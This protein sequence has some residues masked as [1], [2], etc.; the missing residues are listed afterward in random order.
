M[1]LP[2]PRHIFSNVTLIGCVS[3]ITLNFILSRFL[4]ES[5]AS[6]LVLNL[7]VVLCTSQI[8]YAILVS[9]ESPPSSNRDIWVCVMLVA[10]GVLPLIF[11]GVLVG[12]PLTWFLSN[13]TLAAFYICAKFI[14]VKL[15]WQLLG[16]LN[17]GSLL[18]V[19]L[20]PL[21][22]SEDT[23]SVIFASRLT[24]VLGHPNVT[25]YMAVCTIVLGLYLGKKFTIYMLCAALVTVATFSLTSFLALFA[26]LIVLVV[27]KKPRQRLFVSK[28]ALGASSF[29]LVGV[30]V[31]G[32]NLGPDLFTN[33]S[34]IWSWLRSYGTP[35]P[36]GYGLGFL[37]QQQAAG[38]V[39]WVHAHNQLMMNY[40]T[41]GIVGLLVVCGLLI[42]LMNGAEH[43]Q[44]SSALF[45]MLCVECTTEIPLFLDYPSGRWIGA[46]LVLVLIRSFR[47][48]KP[49][50]D[51]ITLTVARIKAKSPKKDQ[52]ET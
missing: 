37:N 52:L 26:G 38:E 13:V 2:K 40:F 35:P 15:V 47:D 32:L 22:F 12:N 6:S 11:K 30:I 21:A 23:R 14:S 27:F 10:C 29:P 44:L 28:L 42:F 19:F 48:H 17:I 39:V 41:Q 7:L 18:T 8:I 25:A 50:L 31:L 5:S 51:N 36:T 49:V 45:V 9:L 43:N 4:L 20:G 34:S 3:L 1:P 33:R 16:A 46:V 24:G